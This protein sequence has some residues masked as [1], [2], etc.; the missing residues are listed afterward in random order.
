MN[1]FDLL[2]P[3]NTCLGGQGI[4]GLNDAV[5]TVH[6]FAPLLGFLFVWCGMEKNNKT[7]RLLVLIYII[8]NFDISAECVF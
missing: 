2:S 1:I 4:E 7:C 3:L 6:D 8:A 5:R